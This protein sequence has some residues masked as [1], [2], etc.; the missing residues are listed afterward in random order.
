[1]CECTVEVTSEQRRPCK[2]CCRPG[3][4][5]RIVARLGKKKV[6]RKGVMCNACT[7][8]LTIDAKWQVKQEA[9]PQDPRG[10][11]RGEFAEVGR[12]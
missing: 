10:F 3:R 5:R 2:Y 6:V 4:P 12:V 8:R 9:Q 7:H 11:T 1:M